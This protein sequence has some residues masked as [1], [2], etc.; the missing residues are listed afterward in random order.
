MVAHAATE[1]GLMEIASLK[2][3]IGDLLALAL[4]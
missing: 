2:S 3:R 4:Q 1:P